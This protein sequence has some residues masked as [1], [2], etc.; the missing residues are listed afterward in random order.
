MKKIRIDAGVLSSAAAAIASAPQVAETPPTGNADD[1]SADEEKEG[2]EEPM[3]DSEKEDI[4][5]PLSPISKYV[6]HLG[7]KG[8]YE[9]KA[10]NVMLKTNN[11]P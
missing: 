4:T 5:D 1:E 7:V 6:R 11:F 3:D 9:R 2:E 10:R 8:Q